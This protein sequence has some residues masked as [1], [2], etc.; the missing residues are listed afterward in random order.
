MND[1]KPDAAKG[2]EIDKLI[3]DLEHLADVAVG[4]CPQASDA[5]RTLIAAL[6]YNDKVLVDSAL[7]SLFPALAD[8]VDECIPKEINLS[9]VTQES[10][11]ESWQKH[12]NGKAYEF[13]VFEDI[14]DKIESIID[15]RITSMMNLRKLVNDL[16]KLGQ[17]VEKA[18]ALDE[19]IRQLR[20]FREDFLKR[21]PS[22]KQ[23]LPIDRDAISKAREAIRGGAKGMTKDQMIWRGK[24]SEKSV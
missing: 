3:A 8:V 22:P 5:A 12:I 19:G 9:A 13:A 4:M 7:T 16:G 20:R 11:G 23:P 6:Q 14:K 1:T 2:S 24:R 10:L 17:T 15:E 18:Q 21:W